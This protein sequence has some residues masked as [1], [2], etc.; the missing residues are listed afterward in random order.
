M[1]TQKILELLG[2]TSDKKMETL[3]REMTFPATAEES[4]NDL[5]NAEL[6]GTKKSATDHQI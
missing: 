1:N 3:K 4:A 6:Y 5:L 2:T